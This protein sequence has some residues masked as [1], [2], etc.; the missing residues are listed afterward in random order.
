[1]TPLWQYHWHELIWV[2]SCGS[3]FVHIIPFLNENLTA[4]CVQH[5]NW[6]GWRFP[7]WFKNLHTSITKYSYLFYVPFSFL[8]HYKSS[9]KCSIK[10]SSHAGRKAILLWERSCVHLI[11]YPWVDISQ[12]VIK[13]SG[14]E[15]TKHHVWTEH[16]CAWLDGV[17]SCVGLFKLINPVLREKH[18]I[19]ESC[20]HVC[21]CRNSAIITEAGKW[22][23][24]LCSSL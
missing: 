13:Q 24:K 7:F 3:V 23:L 12:S 10:Y 22:Q 18:Y 15:A 21:L 2:L 17:R 8:I 9:Y 19:W 1:M 14:W 5:R 4:V 20:G 16:S 11:T 6:T